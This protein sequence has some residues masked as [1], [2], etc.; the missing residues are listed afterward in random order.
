MS[1]TT[2]IFGKTKDGSLVLN[3]LASRNCFTCRNFFQNGPNDMSE[4]LTCETALKKKRKKK[5]KILYSSN[6]PMLIKFRQLVVN[7]IIEELQMVF[8]TS[9]VINSN[10]NVKELE[11]K[12]KCE[13]LIGY[14]I[15]PLQM[16][17]SKV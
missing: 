9:S 6:H 5:L 2:V 14:F 4:W 12:I 7:I 3:P 16:L 1:Q 15:L 11:R 13:N 8:L 17:T 10:G